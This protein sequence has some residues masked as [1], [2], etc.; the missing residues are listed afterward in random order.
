MANFS[1]NISHSSLP[2]SPLIR[3]KCPRGKWCFL[4][5]HVFAGRPRAEN[6][7]RSTSLSEKSITINFLPW[8]I[9]ERGV[10][11]RLVIE[12]L[13]RV[14]KGNDESRIPPSSPHT[15]TASR[16]FILSPIYRRGGAGISCGP[17]SSRGH[18]VGLKGQVLHTLSRTRTTP[19]L[20]PMQMCDATRAIKFCVPSPLLSNTSESARHH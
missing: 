15:Y 17:I 18:L 4:V 10:L 20:L 7:P 12:C 13:L 6:C 11:D 9:R 14:E 8:R 2:L 5:V 16:T 1:L 3:F 19:A